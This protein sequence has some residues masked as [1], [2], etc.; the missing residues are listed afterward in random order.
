MDVKNTFLHG[1]LMEI[2]Y[3][4]Q[5]SGFVDSSH[6]DYVCHLNKSLYGLKQAPRAWYSRFASYITSIDFVG[7]RI[8]LC[9]SIGMVQVHHVYFFMLMILCS[10]LRLIHYCVVSL[11]YFTMSL[12]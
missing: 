10:Q 8:L 2:V 9:S 5:P 7:A 12:L 1:T 3:C 6:L 4:E 11:I